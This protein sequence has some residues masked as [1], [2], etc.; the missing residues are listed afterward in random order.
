MMSQTTA[1]LSLIT[2]ASDLSLC[3]A[4]ATPPP[5]PLLRQTL[6]VRVSLA[7]RAWLVCPG[8]NAGMHVLT[9]GANQL[10]LRGNSFAVT[11]NVA[12]IS[13]SSVAANDRVPHSSR[14]WR[15][16]GYHR[17][18]PEILAPHLLLIFA[19]SAEDG[20]HP[21]TSCKRLPRGNFGSGNLL[22]HTLQ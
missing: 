17:S 9:P 18:A 14:S 4:S 10:A 11:T 15:R 7:L 2:S 13:D 8:A 22:L 5:L 1:W 20:A 3:T 6:A 16:V 12:S 19:R 21:I